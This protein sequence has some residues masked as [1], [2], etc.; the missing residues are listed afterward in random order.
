MSMRIYKMEIVLDTPLGDPDPTEDE[1]REAWKIL[2]DDLD[3]AYKVSHYVQAM[4]GTRT[5]TAGLVVGVEDRPGEDNT[6]PR[7]LSALKG[8]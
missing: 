2:V 7:V 3:L 1:I 6:D 5:K 4:I 8:E